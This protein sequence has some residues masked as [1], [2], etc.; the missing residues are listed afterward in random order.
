MSYE[1]SFF[2]RVR[3]PFP[4]SDVTPIFFFG[5]KQAG[6]QYYAHVRTEIEEDRSLYGEQCMHMSNAKCYTELHEK[7]WGRTSLISRIVSASMCSEQLQ[8]WQRLRASDAL[9]KR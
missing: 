2:V 5:T 3:K 9:L 8:A 7:Y 4:T 1:I 6:P